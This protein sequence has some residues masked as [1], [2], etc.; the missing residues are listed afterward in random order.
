MNDLKFALRQLLKSP[1]FA[2][3]AV[4][5]LAIGIG[6]NTAIF[7]VLNAV[8]LRSL[9]VK[10]PH[11][12]RVVNWSG[13]NVRLAHWTG[14]GQR[15]SPT[16][17]QIYGAF[18][19]PV[20]EDFQRQVKGCSA[21]FSFFGLSGLTVGGPNGATTA[22][23]LMVSGNFFEGY[24]A[25]VFMGRNLLPSDD[26]SAS[27]PVA[28]ITHRFW[29]KVFGLDPAVLGQTITLNQ[30]PFSIVG[31]LPKAYCGPEI[32]DFATVYVPMSAQPRLSAGHPLE[33]RDHWWAR[34]MARLEPGANETQI[35][36][37][38]KGIF[39]QTLSAPGQQTRAEQPEI[40][41]QD[42][43][44]GLLGIRRVMALGI[45]LIMGAVSLVLVIA[46]ANLAGL[47]LARGSARQH[48]L[49][50][51]AA[52]GAGRTRLIRQL[53][54]ESLVLSLAGA[55]LGLVLAA[56]VRSI[57]LS[58]IPD[59]LQGFKFH[60]AMDFRV[61]LFALGSACLTAL[62][63]GLLPAL[64]V[65]RVDLCSTL[66]SQV[67]GGTP[68][69]RLGRALVI[70]Q[71]SLSVL[72]VVASGLL[73]Q[74]LVN[75]HR[76]DLG[77]NPDQLLV[78]R[79]EPGQAGLEEEGRMQFYDQLQ[80]VVQALPG[81]RSVGL[82]SDSLL[83]G[84]RAATAFSLP[85]QGDVGRHSPMADHLDVNEDFF[86]TMD[87]PLLRGRAFVRSDSA[88]ES[89]VAVVNK[90]FAETFFGEED[91]LGQPLRMSGSTDCVIVGV[92][93]N[94]KYDRPQ[95][96]IEPTVYLFHRQGN[97]GAMS[98]EVRTAVNPLNLGPGVRAAVAQLNR[99]IPV[100]NLSTQSQLLVAS[101]TPER[102]FSALAGLL[103][104]LGVGLSVMGLYALLAFMV[105]RRRNE[106]G[107]RL[108]LGAR[109]IDIARRVTFNALGLAGIGLLIGIPAA[110]AL[111]RVLRSVLFG[112]EPHDPLTL[113]AA[114]FVV[115]SL[116]ALAAW[117]PARRAARV[118]P[119][120]ALRVE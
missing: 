39:L 58:F 40:L 28:V 45:G 64:R 73:L 48:E 98:F 67:G 23:A 24:G 120:I 51:R 88:S 77:F 112:V 37:A 43:S 76:V 34:I 30:H 71:V 78:F 54:S 69:L 11:R 68:S 102:L 53:L 46:C 61:F 92:C 44:R 107:V 10:D 106:I 5:T 70:G 84:R 27:G 87:I 15:H 9:P 20:Y 26:A 80:E 18:P 12:L 85:G 101:I 25:D 115:L 79:V 56:W 3:V 19:Y 111:C 6:A 7:S 74:T 72:L 97:P 31:V 41:L 81:V 66:K 108:A 93:G 109:R 35:V 90:I 105:T 22:D 60:V 14:G 110:L 38:M 82:S 94:A 86:R 96:P 91:P 117:I 114:A 32:G 63:C 59:V 113:L 75:L 52:L 21:V 49:G 95:R 1:G 116:A 29:E 55:A 103:A 62:L 17:A 99:A 119:M 13:H 36:A 100:E 50:V 8:W 16:G 65:S 118:D 89:R 57:F 4:L 104:S 33:A 47:L 2:T 42:G 83:G